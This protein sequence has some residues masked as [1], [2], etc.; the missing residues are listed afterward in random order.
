MWFLHNRFLYHFLIYF[1][2]IMFSWNCR[3]AQGLNFRRALNNFCRNNKVDVVALQETRCSGIVARKAIKRLGFK[4]H[5]VSEAHG[6]SGGIWLLWN[7]Q[8]VQFEVI[9]NDFHFIHVKV[10]EKDNDPWF[11]TVVYA[12]P[13]ENER[14]ATW[15]QLRV[16]ADG[17]R[18]P[19]MMVGDFNEIASPGEKKGGAQHDPR[20]CL[21]FSNWINECKLIEVT[22]TG[23]K[24]TWRGPKWNGRDRVF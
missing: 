17:I 22:T 18:E 21:N 5:I 1:L 8:D 10:K 6:F 24:F 14:A 12:S 4:N 2:M 9:Q 7:R 23:T 15:H 20:K 16:L 13:R 3:G 11:L 19:W